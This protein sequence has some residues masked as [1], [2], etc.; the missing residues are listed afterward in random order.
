M[1]TTEEIVMFVRDWAT[2]R[3]CSTELNH[4]DSQAIINEFDDWLEPTSEQIEVM[5]LFE[6]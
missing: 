4:C 6:A 3:I 5:S 2:N 1:K